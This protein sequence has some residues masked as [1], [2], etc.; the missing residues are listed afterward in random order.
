MRVDRCGAQSATSASLRRVYLLLG[1]R[2]VFREPL[3]HGSPNNSS[4]GESDIED[5]KLTSDL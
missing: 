5:K 3:T 4:L 2:K 1:H